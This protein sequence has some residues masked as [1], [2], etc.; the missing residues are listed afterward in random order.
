MS[1]RREP[2]WGTR[3][4]RGKYLGFRKV[5]DDSG[6]WIARVRED[7][8]GKQQYK[9][10]G[11]VRPNFDYEAA[12]AAAL[13]W[14]KD[15]EAGVTRD[16]VTVADGRP[17][18][19]RPHGQRHVPASDGQAEFHLAGGRRRLGHAGRPDARPTVPDSE[20]GHCDHGCQRTASAANERV[21]GT[22]RHGRPRRSGR[23]RWGGQCRHQRRGRRAAAWASRTRRAS[24]P[25]RMRLR[26][27][28][29]RFWHS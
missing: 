17:T 15:A 7:G 20:N 5:D 1:P 3:I 8:T 11:W 10:L 29:Q 28:R 19:L 22:V 14:F 4:S 16:V 27:R 25:A 9:A 2:Y 26:P 24:R 13:A 21:G 6:T 23:D 18:A 12:K